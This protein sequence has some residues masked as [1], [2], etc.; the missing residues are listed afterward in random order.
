MTI[1][2]NLAGAYGPKLQKYLLEASGQ[3]DDNNRKRA[4]SEALPE[5]QKKVKLEFDGRGTPQPSILSIPPL[6][7]GIVP[8]STIY[9]LANDNSLASF[10]VMQLP[11][12]LVQQIVLATIYA[13]DAE[14]LKSAVEVGTM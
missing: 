1:R 13:C 2:N 11:Q 10:D 7:E 8:L 14:R 5:A 12:H 9:N 4:S 6:P 3:T